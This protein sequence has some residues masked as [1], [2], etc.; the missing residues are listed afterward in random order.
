[1]ALLGLD[2]WFKRALFVG[3]MSLWISQGILVHASRKDGQITYNFTTVALIT[4][5]AKLLIS[6]GAYLGEKD[7]SPVTLCA[8]LCKHAKIWLLYFIPALLYCIY[9]NLTFVNLEFFDPVRPAYWQR[10]LAAPADLLPSCVALLSSP[11]TSSS[12][13][14]AWWS[15]ACS[16]SCC[17]I[18][19]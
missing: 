2:T 10:L 6:I 19:V 17:L 15:R 9:N 13:S 16:T 3:Y 5:F 8:E 4:E 18:S 7:H 12:H 14:S 11:L 1:M